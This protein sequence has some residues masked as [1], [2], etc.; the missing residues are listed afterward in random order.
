M[1]LLSNGAVLRHGK[2]AEMLNKRTSWYFKVGGYTPFCCPG[3]MNI[4]D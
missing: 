4:Q 2:V 1:A 3:L